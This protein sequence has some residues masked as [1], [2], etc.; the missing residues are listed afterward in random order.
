MFEYSNA[1][2]KSFTYDVISGLLACVAAY[3]VIL[4]LDPPI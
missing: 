2:V 3:H 4:A 1:H